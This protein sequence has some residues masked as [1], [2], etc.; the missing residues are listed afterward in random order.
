MFLS[1]IL[2]NNVNAAGLILPKLK[3]II[4]ELKKLSD[5]VVPLK[6]PS[7]DE[8]IK[9]IIKKILS[10]DFTAKPEQYKCSQC[11]YKDM[12]SESLA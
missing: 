5:K 2:I 11:D 10:G 12:C 9:P 7:L 3:P 8:K 1:L 6:K 4:N